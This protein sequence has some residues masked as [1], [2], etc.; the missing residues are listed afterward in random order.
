MSSHFGEVLG[1]TLVQRTDGLA[2]YSLQ[3]RPEHCNVHGS[4]HGGV[5]MA[6]LD[7]AGLWAYPPEPGKEHQ[8]PRA[9]TAAFTCSF[10]RA[11]VA[12]KI[13]SLRAT[14]QLVKRGRT[15]YFASVQLHSEPDEQL[16]A[17]G[18]GVYTLITSA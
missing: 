12:Q 6:V 13:H 15:T 16:I 2:V 3:V 9:A 17:T 1:L 5:V 7:A 8:A 18:Q 14:A 11:A 4:V 10:L